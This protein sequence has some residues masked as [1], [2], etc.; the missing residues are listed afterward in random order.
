MEGNYGTRIE[1]MQ[2]EV[3]VSYYIIATESVFPD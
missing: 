2:E 1:N 3:A